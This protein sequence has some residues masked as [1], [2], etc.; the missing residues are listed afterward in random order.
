MITILFRYLP[1]QNIHE[2]YTCD[3]EYRAMYSGSKFTDGEQTIFGYI[4]EMDAK[5][6]SNLES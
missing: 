2:P 3:D 5:V 6:R 4:T 1:F